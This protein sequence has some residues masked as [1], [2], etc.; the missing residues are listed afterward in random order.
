MLAA[1]LGVYWLRGHL[2]PT[3]EVSPRLGK[4]LTLDEAVGTVDPGLAAAARQA[5]APVVHL[6]DVQLVQ[7][8]GG[9]VGVFVGAREL[10]HLHADGRV[11]VPLPVEIGDNL[12]RFD[13][14]QP[15][16]THP[17]DGW[18][19]H[20]VRAGAEESTT[21]LLRLAHVLYEMS[22]RGLGDPVTRAELDAFTHT[23]Q[24]VAAMTAATTRWGLRMEQPSRAL[25]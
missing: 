24:C 8:R 14:V 10:A 13:I 4:R 21:W 19:T 20:S 6:E 3:G 22:H 2:H 15:H 7:V 11:D 12:R 1:I 5:L 17:D 25:A 9:L 18:Y 16:P 23:D